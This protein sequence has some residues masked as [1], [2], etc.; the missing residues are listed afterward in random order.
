MQRMGK[1]ETHLSKSITLLNVTSVANA[2]TEII[3]IRRKTTL[4]MEKAVPHGA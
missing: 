1:G 3:C 2:K 4:K